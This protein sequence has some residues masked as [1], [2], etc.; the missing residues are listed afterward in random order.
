MTKTQERFSVSTS[1]LRELHA[2]REPWTLLKELVQNAWDEAPEA[3]ICQVEVQLSERRGHLVIVVEDDGSGFSN[4]ADA[5]TLMGSTGKRLDPT[6]RGRFNLGEK[7]IVSVAREA[8]V[9]TVGATV[10]FPA[11][12]GRAVKRNRRERGTAIT[13][14]MPWRWAEQ[15]PLLDALNRFRPTDCA[16]VVNGQK[17]ARREP[18]VSFEAKLATVLQ[19]APGE[20]LRRTVRRT[21]VDVLSASA[22]G[23][24]LYELGIPVQPIEIAFDVDVQQKIP[25]P[26]NRD[27]VSD[28]YLQALSAEVLNATHGLLDE[29]GAADTWVRTALEDDR[30]A[31]AA[32]QDI[33][34]KRYGEKVAI[35]STNTDANM[36][37]AEAGY[38]VLNPRSMS[39]DERRHIRDLAGVQSANDIFGKRQIVESRMVELTPARAGFADWVKQQASKVGLRARVSFIE[40]Q[41]SVV[42]DC[43]AATTTPTLRFNTWHL[44]DEW[45]SQRGSDQLELVIHEL[46][47]AVADTPMEHGP[48][49]GEACC[50]VGGIL[51]RGD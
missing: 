17:V 49:W 46:A 45:L 23:A 18:L 42:A 38:E 28:G 9:E 48:R 3:T 27:T 10:E 22:G 32:V 29:D 34:G 15:Q 8:R 43:T 13:L 24:W 50:K 30:V 4:P 36:R 39:P 26:P 51:A 25:M 16:L 12:G 1:G 33:V 41:C 19:S 40:A 7:E 35:W 37:A 21:R 47:H 6:K 2:D 31:A 20:P 14:E 11:A 44:S 5:W